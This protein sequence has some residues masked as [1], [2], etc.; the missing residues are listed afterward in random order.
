MTKY[1]GWGLNKSE[2]RIN[3]NS[4][5]RLNMPKTTTSEDRGLEVQYQTPSRNFHIPVFKLCAMY[6]H[7]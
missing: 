4:E 2:Y 7:T 1:L 3:V 6:V 5:C